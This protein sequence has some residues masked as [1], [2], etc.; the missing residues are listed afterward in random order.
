M[1]KKPRS[2]YLS[3]CI[4]TAISLLF[5]IKIFNKPEPIINNID[6]CQIVRI[7]YNDEFE[8]GNYNEIE[9]TEFDEEA[10]LKCISGYNERK[11]LN[12]YKGGLLSDF[13]IQIYIHTES[14]LKMIGFGK[15]DFSYSGSN[16]FKHKIIN[17][18]ALKDELK[19]LI[20][21]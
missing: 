11:T 17:S 10:I 5:G 3:I 6:N 13:E 16:N 1:V 14:G 18:S 19:L 20:L 12:R 8:H 4:I 21:K 2:L 15:E 7:L 9:I